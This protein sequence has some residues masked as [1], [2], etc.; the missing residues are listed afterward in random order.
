MVS[1]YEPMLP[2]PDLTEEEKA[3]IQRERAA[4]LTPAPA[5][6]PAPAVPQRV[7]EM[8]LPIPQ[9]TPNF[10]ES[11]ANLLDPQ[12][13]RVLSIPA[14]GAFSVQ[15]PQGLRET[16]QAADEYMAQ[17]SAYNAA[18]RNEALFAQQ[19]PQVG[20]PSDVFG[21]PRGL[22]VGPNSTLVPMPGVMTPAEED[23]YLASRGGAA[24]A[25][26]VSGQEP[27]FQPEATISRGE[28]R[29]LAARQLKERARSERGVGLGGGSTAGAP[30]FQDNEAVLAAIAGGAPPVG[31]TEPDPDGTTYPVL[32]NVRDV[33]GRE[34]RLVQVAP[35]NIG[36]YDPRTGEWADFNPDDWSIEGQRRRRGG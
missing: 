18:P 34:Y 32:G 36:V 11:M 14:N 8:P 26:P 16:Q 5:P 15:T 4:L 30:S 1:F 12:G 9:G 35:G 19:P 3:R 22:T 13:R 7:A 28:E 27:F 29:A 20:Q 2:E 6:V 31:Q 33:L 17:L 21:I 23:A 10:A 24:S 25:A